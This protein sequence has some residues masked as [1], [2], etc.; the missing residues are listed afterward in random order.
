ML[1]Y[2]VSILVTNNVADYAPYK[3]WIEPAKTFPPKAKILTITH[4]KLEID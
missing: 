1:V 3:F 2:Q 4:C